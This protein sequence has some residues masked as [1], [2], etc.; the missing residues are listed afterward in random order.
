LPV[1]AFGNVITA[2]AAGGVADPVSKSLTLPGKGGIETPLGKLIVK[3]NV[4][5]PV[6]PSP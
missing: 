3:V 1:L 6:L 2:S 5:E 4:A